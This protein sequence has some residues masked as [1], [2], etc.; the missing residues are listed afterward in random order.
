MVGLTVFIQ[1][2][3]LLGRKTT[4]CRISAMQRYDFWLYPLSPYILF[5]FPTSR[6]LFDLPK[7]HAE[8]T[9]RRRWT[10]WRNAKQR[11]PKVRRF[12][13]W[14]RDIER[15]CRF[16]ISVGGGVWWRWC[17][18]EA[19]L[20]FGRFIRFFLGRGEFRL[21]AGEKLGLVICNRVF[22]LIHIV[23]AMQVYIPYTW[24]FAVLFTI[25][26]N[27][28]LPVWPCLSL[29]VASRKNLKLNWRK[30]WPLLQEWA[31][32]RL[33]YLLHLGK[34]SWHQVDVTP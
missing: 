27:S 19:R 20:C 30:N 7:R 25:T 2:K 31:L 9:K 6:C 14:C 8:A 23:L 34:F 17:F 21:V 16:P 1:T 33:R 4:R 3:I 18:W 32:V 13:I 29:V 28:V 12:W 15:R 26:T 11:P 24:L 5:R 10:P 22:L